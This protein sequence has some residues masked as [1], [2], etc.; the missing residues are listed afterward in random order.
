[1][2]TYAFDLL[3]AIYEEDGY[4]PAD[5]PSLILAN[6]LYGTEIDPRA[7]V[8]AA[9][10]L[11]M[12]ARARQR[13]F[14]NKQVEPNICVLEP[15]S[16]T[17]FELD[18]LVT[19]DGDRADEEAFWNQFEHADTFG[20][21]I[22]PRD[23]LIVRLRRKLDSSVSGDDLLGQDLL[24]RASRVLRQAEYLSQRYS[25]VVAN[26]PYMGSGNMD[27]R[28]SPWVKDNYFD[29]KQDLYGCF[30][31]RG[32]LLAR[33]DGLVA[34]I[35]GDT[36]M[37]IKTFEAF[38]KRLLDKHTFLCFLHLR[39]T[40]YHADTFGANAAFVVSKRAA[41]QHKSTY[42]N[43]EAPSA[44]A[45]SA[46]LLEVIRSPGAPGRFTAASEDFMAIPG[47]P[48]VFWADKRDIDILASG[49]RVEDYVQTREGL[50]TGDNNRFL[51]RW[52]EVSANRIAWGAPGDEEVSTRW[53]LYLKGGEV[54]RWFGNLDYVVDWEHDGRRQLANVDPQSGRVRSH[55]YN[56]DYAFR[57][58]LTWSGLSSSHFSARYVPGGFMF[59]ATGPM[60][61]AWNSERLLPLIG[62]LNS[63]S[64][65][66]FMRM[67]SPTLHFKIGHVLS[68]PVRL[69]DSGFESL[70]AEVTEAIE[71][72]R[73]VWNLEE[74]SFGFTEL[75]PSTSG[76]CV[77]E[78][79]SARSEY[80]AAIA[81]DLWD[82]DR[83]IDD[84]VDRSLGYETDSESLRLDSTYLVDDSDVP[85]E[86]RAL[87]F[88]AVGCMFGRYSL[89]EAGLILANQG[90]TLHEYL[91]KI[92]NPTFMPD[93]DNVIPIVD[94]DWFEDDVVAR[95]RQFL[96]VAFGDQQFEENLRFVTESLGVKDLRDYFVKSF[97]K[98]H[99]QRY[100]KR[101]IYWLF[102]SPKGSFNALI[103]MHRYTPS[104]AST[105]LNEYLREFKAKLDA[106]RQ[107]HERLAVGSGLPRQQAAALKEADRLRK[108]LL[109][110]D[111]YE[112]D[113]LYPLATQQVQIDLDDGVKANYP[114][115]VAALKKIPGLEASD[116]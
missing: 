83:R 12:K 11:T 116:E 8:L 16:F 69:D 94:G 31:S 74:T 58:G 62:L 39:D 44:E 72:G 105:V 86:V 47:S 87:V 89:D 22:R 32:N 4:A 3:H 48:I 17:P 113:V 18:V 10:A 24:V 36:W 28:L 108:V 20:A 33:D 5:I 49:P 46:K 29:E 77:R 41:T 111:E 63:S 85:A 6:N 50:T 109:E 99:V 110:L 2:L 40:A 93:S 73:A 60:G 71:R 7:G 43:L 13:T 81:Q 82:I 51:R 19:P 84:I 95:F 76:L 15:M 78:W 64:T 37:T 38:R 90:D 97:Y 106:S 96:R 57:E 45:K 88:Y 102:S 79:V 115:F 103:Y 100:K 53:F 66:R 42:I 107:H 56:G 101:P 34:M 114:K 52:H 9:F 21:L 92:P 68:L 70:G 35:V 54:R 75:I 80:R 55:N 65:G 14:F 104:T 27:A 30:V 26:P 1:M 67:M 25:I 91:A 59:D 112:H 61:F 23:D 98:D